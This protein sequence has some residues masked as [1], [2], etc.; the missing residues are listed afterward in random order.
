MIESSVVSFVSMAVVAVV[1]AI[2]LSN[3]VRSDVVDDLVDE[4]VGASSRHL[5]R[6]YPNTDLATASPPALADPINS[7]PW[8]D[9]PTS[10]FFWKISLVNLDC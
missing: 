5:L 3:K 7:S 10:S 1:L 4:A 9:N 2:V 6:A 8:M